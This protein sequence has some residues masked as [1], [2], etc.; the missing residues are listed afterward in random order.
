[1]IDKEIDKEKIVAKMAGLKELGSQLKQQRE[2]KSSPLQDYAERLKIR[3]NYLLSLE[4]GQP[5]NLPGAVFY[6]SF[7]K[8][9]AN[10]L[11]LNGDN[12][13]SE[14]R[15]ALQEKGLLG[16]F[17]LSVN[18]PQT[19]QHGLDKH[20]QAKTLAVG[21]IG[22]GSKV[23]KRQL[24]VDKT[25]FE[26]PE[27]PILVQPYSNLRA[28]GKFS[29]KF[30]IDAETEKQALRETIFSPIFVIG[31]AIAVVLLYLGGV[32]VTDLLGEREKGSSKAEIVADSSQTAGVLTGGDLTT[33]GLTASGRAR[34]G[35]GRAA[36]ELLESVVL[37]KKE[38]EL[39]YKPKVYGA[40]GLTR[41]TL[42]AREKCWIAVFATET[43]PGL[44]QD[45]E[46]LFVGDLKPGDLYRVP[47]QLGVILKAGNLNALRFEVHD[48]GVEPFRIQNPSG[49][50]S[51]E[52]VHL[53]NKT[54][55]REGGAIA[56]ERLPV[57]REIELLREHRA[58]EALE[59]QNA[60]Q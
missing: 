42:E 52:P 39:A 20:R 40:L 18:K 16:K 50:M 34:A 7:T 32:I 1:M 38:G 48:V 14:T 13:A 17:D 22:D 54:A 59:K 5:E 43:E 2:A 31:A 51:L 8:S 25:E 9:Y 33:D 27:R 12:F 41:V 46:L 24:A 4:N 10:A 26:M 6:I 55:I 30:G 58:K 35:S 15:K 45:A 11:G 60:T 23:Q 56:R 3:Y 47:V 49:F 21:D 29:K 37:E 44:V 19:S 36:G 53:R 28:S 57:V